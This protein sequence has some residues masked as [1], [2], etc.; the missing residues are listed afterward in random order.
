MIDAMAGLGPAGAPGLAAAAGPATAAG[1]G[2]RA[3]RAAPGPRAER[4]AR[5]APL[6][7]P[8]GLVDRPLEQRR[9]ALVFDLTGAAGHL[10]V[11]G[12]PRSGKS[13]ALVHRRARA[14]ADQ[15]PG[16][17]GRARARLRRRR[18]GRA[19]RAAARR[20]GRRRPAAR[21]GAAACSPSSTPRWPGG[22]GCSASAGDHLDRRVPGPPGGRRVPRRAGHR[23]AAGRRRLPH[24]ARRLRRP[25]GPAAADRGQGALLRAA[26]RACRPTGGASCARRSR[27][28]SASGSSCASAIR[29][30]PRWTGGWPPRCRPGPGTGSPPTERPSVL[31]AP[32]TERSGSTHGRRW[33]R[34]SPRPGRGRRSRRCG[35]CPT[36][37]TST[38]CRRPAASEPG[39][40][41]GVDERLERV[42]LDF[43][44]EPH[45]LCF[46]DAESGKTA[47]LRLLAHGIC[48]RLAPDQARIVAVDSA[49]DPARR[50]PRHRT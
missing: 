8:F 36:A 30:S 24:P 1:R 43:A 27:T 49:P 5:R 11:V 32:R 34:R 50:A 20:H 12:G 29:W 15:H 2:A 39:F 18:A 7:V 35:C 37:S 48:A 21:S 17:A 16:R 46:G 4:G 41:L 44:A 25:G 33:W 42:E 28:C 3:A 38:S 9:D 13:T 19:G 31:A 14:G 26:P 47:L 45:L 23:P 10:A 40:R 6:R 22:S